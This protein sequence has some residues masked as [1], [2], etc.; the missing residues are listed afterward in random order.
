MSMRSLTK[1]PSIPPKTSKKQSTQLPVITRV[2]RP[3]AHPLQLYTIECMGV[4]K[5]TNEKK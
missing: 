4:A 3:T 2:E 5:H 1:T